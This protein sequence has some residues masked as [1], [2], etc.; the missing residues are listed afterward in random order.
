MKFIILLLTCSL[1][2]PLWS[3]DIAHSEFNFSISAHKLKSTDMHYSFA[4]VKKEIFNKEA[5]PFSA[6]LSPGHLGQDREKFTLIRAVFPVK[7]A[8]GIFDSEKFNDL[9]FIKRIEDSSKV[10]KLRENTFISQMSS[11]RKYQYF[12]KFHFDADDLSSLPDSRVSKKIMELKTSDPLLLSANM[13]IFREMFGFTDYL[14][15]SSE[16]YGFISLDETT[17]LVVL[18]KLAVFPSDDITDNVIERDLLKYIKRIQKS[19]ENS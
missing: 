13:S 6:L 3:K 8:I 2:T 12:S 10:R 9:K 1:S 19:L 17:T 18:I 14:S 5:G 15:E 11:P 16:F 4:S 7:K